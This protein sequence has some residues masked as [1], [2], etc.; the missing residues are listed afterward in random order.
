MDLINKYLNQYSINLLKLSIPESYKNE[1]EK[2]L[3]DFINTDN[4]KKRK[5]V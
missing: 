4:S 3:V 5:L 1:K 2:D